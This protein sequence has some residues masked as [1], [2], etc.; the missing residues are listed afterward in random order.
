MPNTSVLDDLTIPIDHDLLLLS[1]IWLALAT[2][3][4]IRNWLWNWGYRT[5]WMV[6]TREATVRT[7]M[8]V[9]FWPGTVVH[10]FAHALMAFV[11]RVPV[12]GISLRPRT[13]ATGEE[14]LGYVT[15]GG[16]D[17]FRNFLVSMAPLP[18]AI[19]LLTGIS[20][21]LQDHIQ[22]FDLHPAVYPLLGYA[23]LQI[24]ESMFPSSIDIRNTGKSA[25]LAA[26]A[27]FIGSYALLLARQS[28]VTDASPALQPL[29][30]ALG[31]GLVA[32][33]IGGAL[34]MVVA[35]AGRRQAAVRG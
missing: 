29:A 25:Y 14:T 30:I 18:V 1:A 17:G 32:T 3:Y 22:P 5:V 2:L 23:V 16:S 8:A 15:V 19:A 7:L 33:I 28:P 24:S 9:L 20:T 35:Q 10:E 12:H 21:F 6:T 31:M 27:V 26:V 13:L 4:L 11:L 34:M